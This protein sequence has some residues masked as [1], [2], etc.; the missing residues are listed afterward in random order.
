MNEQPWDE[1]PRIALLRSQ[2]H[3]LPIDEYYRAAL[4][5]SIHTY[6]NQILAR[7]IDTPAGAWDDLEA[8]Q[9]VTLGDM[10]ERRMQELV[11]RKRGA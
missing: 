5:I 7:T 10:M 4:L 11:D 3:G 8:L 9:Q 6:R 2:V 1:H